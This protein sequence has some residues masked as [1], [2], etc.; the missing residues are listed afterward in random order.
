MIQSDQ[1]RDGSREE[2]TTSAALRS[3]EL[4]LVARVV[5]SSVLGQVIPLGG[6]GGAVSSGRVS[7]GGAGEIARPFVQV[8][9]DGV[10]PR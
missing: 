2:S 10:A 1:L 3:H 4:S 5:P 9:R 6:G 8:R 7:P